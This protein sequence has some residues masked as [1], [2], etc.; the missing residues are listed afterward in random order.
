MQIANPTTGAISTVKSNPDEM[1]LR[2][3]MIRLYTRSQQRGV[4]SITATAFDLRVRSLDPRVDSQ[5]VAKSPAL[6]HGALPAFAE[7]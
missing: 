5:L 2:S 1:S 3:C 4:I 7:V 6:S